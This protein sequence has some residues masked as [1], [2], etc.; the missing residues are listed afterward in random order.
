MVAY[1]WKHVMLCMITRSNSADRRVT[2]WTFD[3]NATF[4]EDVDGVVRLLRA[5]LTR[6]E[7]MFELSSLDICEFLPRQSKIKELLSKK[8][9]RTWASLPRGFCYLYP[10]AVLLL[11]LHRILKKASSD[12]DVT[13]SANEGKLDGTKLMSSILFRELL[14]HVHRIPIGYWR[15]NDTDWT[16]MQVEVVARW[17]LGEGSGGNEQDATCDVIRDIQETET[18]SDTRLRVSMR[19]EDGSCSGKLVA[20]HEIIEGDAADVFERCP[21]RSS[22]RDLL[23]IA[24]RIRG[25]EYLRFASEE[26]KSDRDFIK[27]VVRINGYALEFAAPEVRS[28]RDVVILA[29]ENKKDAIEFA[30]EALTSDL[31]FMKSVVRR[32]GLALEFASPELRNNLEVVK[33]ALLQNDDAIRHAGE[34]LRNDAKFMKEIVRKD[35]LDLEFASVELRDDP[36]IVRLALEDHEGAIEFAGEQLRSDPRFMAEVIQKNGSALEFASDELR[37]DPDFVRLALN[38]GSGHVLQFASEN[39][40]SDPKFMREMIRRDGFALELASP[41]LRKDP[42]VVKLAIDRSGVSVL[43]YADKTLR[44][45]PKFM[46]EL[47]RKNEFALQ[48]A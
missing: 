3:S 20:I 30:G 16:T 10:C 36:A 12:A 22:D 45:D 34:K 18:Q 8:N 26:M 14:D 4:L 42:D 19:D 27:E 1:D 15:A 33:L 9:R 35:G 29:I 32:N 17:L 40:K 37:N 47:I 13:L 5:E 2:C 46:K 44:S 24:V 11:L 28:D 38:T 6:V 43:H 48:Y 7:P 39:L 41:D 25:S 23:L 21:E 31:T